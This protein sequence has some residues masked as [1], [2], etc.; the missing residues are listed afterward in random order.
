MLDDLARC[1]ARLPAA[2]LGFL[3]A[4]GGNSSLL[5]AACRDLR[6]RHGL[7]TFLLH[8]F[9]PPDQ[10]GKSAADERGPGI[11][12]GHRETSLMLH[13]RP[14]TVDMSVESANLLPSTCGPTGSSGSAG[15][16]ASADCLTTSVRTATS[17]IPR[18]PTPAPDASPSTARS[19]YRRTPWRR[20]G[21]F[22]SVDAETVRRR[23]D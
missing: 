16:A 1:L 23:P 9:V 17:V 6:R 21:N 7:S 18:R 12:G 2:R 8:P 19:R 22:G 13:L 5:N 11:H 20:F 4:H 3:N 10:G 14:E 15:S